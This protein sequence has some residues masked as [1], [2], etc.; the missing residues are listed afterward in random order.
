MGD[1][2][3]L[4]VIAAIGIGTSLYSGNKQQQGMKKAADQNASALQDA[5]RRRGDQERMALERQTMG[6]HRAMQR[7]Q[8]A[9]AG[10]FQST[11]ATTPLGI[12]G[13]GNVYGKNTLVGG[14]P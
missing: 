14:S 6:A 4:G 2:I 11:V 5:E 13:G 3:S 7:R 12:P 9:L 8:Q 1:P 10:G